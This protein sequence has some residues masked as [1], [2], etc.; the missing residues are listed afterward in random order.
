MRRVLALLISLVMILSLIPTSE[1]KAEESLQAAVARQVTAYASSI[2]QKDAANAAATAMLTNAAFRGKNLTMDEENVMTAMIFNSCLFQEQLIH[3]CAAAAELM[4]QLRTDTL[5]GAGG[6]HWYSSSP[7]YG[8]H[9]FVDGLN[10]S[11][12]TLADSVSLH[13]DPN[14]LLQQYNS[15]DNMLV[16]LCGTA[17]VEY[18]FKRLQTTVEN[19]QYEVSITISDV[20]N[21][22]A[23]YNENYNRDFEKILSMFGQLSFKSFSWECQATF[24]FEVPYTCDHTL[25]SYQWIV[26]ENNQSLISCNSDSFRENETYQY[27]YSKT[28]PNGTVET[29]YYYS[30]QETV[31][32]FHD[33][34]W[35]LTFDTQGVVSFML[36]AVRDGRTALPTLHQFNSEYTWIGYRNR[37]RLT[38]SEKEALNT[39]STWYWEEHYRGAYLSDKFPY[40]YT[41]TYTYRLENVIANDG[42]NMIYLSIYDH[43][44]SETILDSI[45]MDHHYSRDSLQQIWGL[46]ESEDPWLSGVD[47]FINFIG[48]ESV[49]IKGNLQ[50]IAVYENGT[51]HGPVSAFTTAV[52][53]PSC[54]SQGYTLHTCIKCGYS[55]K[56]D[57]TDKFEHNYREKIVA[58]TCTAEGYTEYSCQDCSHA[59]QTN[60]VEKLPHSVTE[61]TSNQDATCTHNGTKTGKCSGCGEKF[62]ITEVGTMLPHTW[63]EVTCTK[64]QT[65]II[66][67]AT[68]GTALG[69]ALWYAIGKAPTCTE[70]G[71]DAYEKCNRCKYSTF[72]QIP[73]LGHD[74]RNHHCIHCGQWDGETLLG[75]VNEDGAID[76]TDAYCI[77]LYYNEVMDLT[78]AQIAAA[79]VNG[80]GE[81]DTTD[82]YYI[83]MLYQEKIDRLPAE[84]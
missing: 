24:C 6:I 66:C 22:D 45:P 72:R 40:A 62:T 32:L 10:Q 52:V 28:K 7:S 37:W 61:Y 33:K 48:N 77:V 59:Y 4:Q 31:S 38:D 2:S 57:Y 44:S 83:V 79:D 55:Y 80:D 63:A 26:G 41:H 12:E 43:D 81:V 25:N 67:G 27:T 11:V 29:L 69:H 65:C 51:N 1:V 9:A 20:F 56:T 78:E 42:E 36:S 13:E 60:I 14:N 68:E 58:P 8:I 17:E 39:T 82:A 35:V 34:P 46:E 23:D 70:V 18:R 3:S 75:D 30:L 16:M 64:P 21:F 49:Q 73:A 47:C 76:T 19:I 50:K 71:W 84:T 53:A 54:T 15:N 74:F 5:R